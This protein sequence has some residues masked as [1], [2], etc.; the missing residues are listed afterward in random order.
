M[1]IESK[2]Q[3]C[4]AR[5][6]YP[7]D[8]GDKNHSCKSCNQPQ[9]H[10][11]TEKFLTDHTLN[12]CPCCG[13][14]HLYKQKD[15]NKNIGVGLIVVGVLLAYFTYGLSLVAVTLIDWLLTRY[16]GQV[17]V[18]YQC[19]AQFRKSPQIERLESFNLSLFD[20]YKNLA[21]STSS[22]PS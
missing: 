21:S 13:S 8:L 19:H 1:L 17:G 5:T 12:Q 2:C 3:S 9:I 14:T 18:C 7:F 20:Y 10:Y 22:H 16:V 4:G 15:F 6:E 11:A